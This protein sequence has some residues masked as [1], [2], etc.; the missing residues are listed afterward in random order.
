MKEII[1]II[2]HELKITLFY[3]IPLRLISRITFFLARIENRFTKKIF[4]KTYKRFFNIELDEYQKKNIDDYKNL[5]DFF[6]RE[7]DFNHRKKLDDERN[8]ISP[9]DGTISGFGEINDSTFI[10]AKKHKYNV[11]ELINEKNHKF[12]NGK[13]VNIYLEPKDC[14]R[15]YMPCDAILSKI[16]NIPGCLYS[17][18]PYASSGIKN[19]YSKNERVVLSFESESFLMTIVM[20]GAVNVGCI[21]LTRHGIITPKK[22]R[23]NKKNDINDKKIQSYKKGE[24]VAMFNL[25]STVIILLSD[26]RGKWNDNIVTSNK[27]LI[28]DE[29]FKLN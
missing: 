3:I 12:S 13:F 21:S 29:I 25:G 5:D 20:V 26:I 10:H 16:T 14:H 27:I 28:R 9:C 23:V 17:V 1:K 2:L 24:E 8:I 6:I 7:L 22:Y 19:L 11:S 4:I 18:A 15:V